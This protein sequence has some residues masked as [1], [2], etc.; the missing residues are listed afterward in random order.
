VSGEVLQPD[1]LSALDRLPPLAPAHVRVA[2]D[3]PVAVHILLNRYRVTGE[4]LTF[5]ISYVPISVFCDI[6]RKKCPEYFVFDNMS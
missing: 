6:E 1:L 5:S 3:R 2:L 4:S